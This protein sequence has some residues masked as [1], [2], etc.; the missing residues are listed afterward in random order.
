MVV[1]GASSGGVE[2]VM[3]L[4]E[5]LPGDLPAAVFVVVHLPPDAR[6]ML[7]ELLRRRGSL[8]VP[9]YEDGA[10]IEYGCVYVAPPDRHLMVEEGRVRLGHGPRENRHRPA[11]DVLFR[12]AARAYGPRVVGVVLSGALDDGTAGLLEIK[13]RGGAAVVQDPKEAL[14]PGMPESALEY[15]DVDYCLPLAEIPSLLVHLA[16]GNIRKPVKAGSGGEGPPDDES[17][18][19]PEVRE[20]DPPGRLSAYTCPECSGP[21]WEVRDGDLVRFRCRV[22]HSYSA[23]SFL[24]GKGEEL[25]AALWAALN[26]L[27]EGASS[28]RRLAE[29]AR[30]QGREAMA[31]RFEDRARIYEERAELIRRALDL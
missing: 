29:R 27:Q 28:A 24:N 30:G 25:E 1:V 20:D 17:P 3:R 26:S 31:S 8:K 22:G 23:E 10:P 4:V 11:V 7:P 13:R 19:S 21:L 12:S 6:S 14:F 15:V 9:A 18:Q 5:G 2:A 16:H